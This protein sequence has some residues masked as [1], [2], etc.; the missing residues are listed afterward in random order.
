V[1]VCV[2]THQRPAGLVRLLGALD[3]LRFDGTPPDLQIFVVDNDAEESAREVVGDLG[4]RMSTPVAYRSE[5]RRGIPQARNAA[6]GAAMGWAD[7]IAF[8]DD[9]DIPE[10]DWL[11]EL[12]G[13]QVE[14]GA[15]A[16]TGP[17]PPRFATPSPAW[18]V[19]GGFFE[20][21]RWP[22]GTR[23]HVA[24]TGNVLVRTQ[25]LAAMGEL[26]D[27]RLARC[28]GED[29]EFFQRFVWSG[30]TIVWCDTAVVH[31][32]VPAS[33]MRLGW[34]LARAFRTGNTEAY[35]A[36]K[37]NTGWRAGGKVAARGGVCVA[38]GLGRILLGF[39]QGR[40]AAVRGLHTASY[41]VGQIAGALGF[42]YAEYR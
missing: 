10:P 16:V 9:D 5:K 7:W 15:D 13:T 11:A 1:A 33:R 4:G 2:I 20:N 26:F 29:S 39:G 37:R 3:A 6:L 28:G 30:H 36:R 41:G 8:V 42:R 12:L 22:T 21:P 18:V 24:F 25:S 31:V 17:C 14:T 38:T 32:Q 27:E 19:A 35:V 40:V 34:I 23:R